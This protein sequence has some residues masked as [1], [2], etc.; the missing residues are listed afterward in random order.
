MGRK[1]AL[2][3]GALF[4]LSCALTSS[5]SASTYTIVPGGSPLT[6]TT[7]AS[8]ETATVTFAGTAGER[9]SLKLNS[10]TISQSYVSIQKPDGTNLASNTLVTSTGSFID[11]KT[12]PVSGTYTIL[13]DP[14]STYT[15]SMTLTLYDVPPD[16]SGLITPGGAAV[17]VTTTTPGQNA[18]QTFIGSPGQRISLKVSAVTMTQAKVSI[19]KPDGTNLVA[20]ML[21]TKSGSFIDTKTL[22]VSG[23]YTVVV[24]PQSSYTG[25]L[26]LTLYDVPPDVSGSITPGGAAVVVTTATPGQNAQLTFAATAGQRISLKLSAVTMTQAKVSITNPGGTNLLAPLVIGSAGT[27]VDTKTLPASGAYTIVIDPQSSYT[28][29]VTLSLYDVPADVSGSI[30]PG[31]AAVTVTATA[32]GQNARLTFAGSAG[33]R[34]SLKISSVTIS[35]SHVV[36]AKPDG[37]NLVGSTLV[38]G[39]GT[40]IDTQTLPLAG[41]YAIAI[42]PAAA[43]V[44]S[45]TLTLYDVPADATAP[46]TPGG[47]AA[48]LAVTTPGQNGRVTFAGTA[49][50][51]ISLAV[52]Q[53]TAPGLTVTITNPDATTLASVK[54]FGTQNAFIDTKVLP[55][56]GTYTILANPSGTGTGNVTLT[57]YDVPADVAA[58]I[59]PGGAPVTA[60]VS[61]PGQ[62]A[63]LTFAGVAGHRVSLRMTNVTIGAVTPAGS[64]VSVLNPDGTALIAATGVTTGG[65]FFDVRTLPATGTYT[66]LLDPAAAN[67]GQMTLTL[68]D[69]P[70]DVSATITTGGPAVT[71]AMNTPGQNGSATFNGTAG[72]SIKLTVTDGTSSSKISIRRPDGTNL[73]S[74]T[75]LKTISAT[76]ATAGTYTIFVDPQAQFTGTVTLTLA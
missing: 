1:R 67:I 36:I 74:P 19:T 10:V 43:N 39:A 68:Y 18:R 8:G 53:I 69:V 71:L 23:T 41:T 46:I 66:I 48:T 6:V 49:G 61:T 12:L 9:I 34:V 72:Q 58:S 15:G 30:T 2:L 51:R 57:L 54:P 70:P 25:A 38:T 45:M 60:A 24:D 56:T 33:Q 55:A 52:T 76:L 42:D 20:P 5:A 14:L 59:T 65:G 28:G 40:F 73:V 4:A 62:N 17:T 22:T 64:H 47:A 31:G 26:T 32:P 50:Q 13:V 29:A 16:V 44:G 35:Q 7:T 37:T 27:F 75:T 21:V 3:G 11:T 63:S